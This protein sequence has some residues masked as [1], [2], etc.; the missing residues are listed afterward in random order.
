[1]LTFGGVYCLFIGSS[2]E[3]NEELSYTANGKGNTTWMRNCHVMTCPKLGNHTRHTAKSCGLGGKPKADC[4]PGLNVYK[5]CLPARLHTFPL[6]HTL[7][8]YGDRT[9]KSSP[10]FLQRLPA[11]RLRQHYLWAGGHFVLLISALR[12]FLAIVTLKAISSWW[13]KG[14]LS[15][16]LHPTFSEPWLLD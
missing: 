7:S 11:Q 9:G 15:S 16:C 6:I 10:C 8:S 14:V 13:Y 5:Y 12:Y 1:M 3:K 4:P 2:R